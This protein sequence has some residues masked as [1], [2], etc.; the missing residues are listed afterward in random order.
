MAVEGSMGIPTALVGSPMGMG[1]YC[2][3]TLE[4]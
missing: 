1:M 3:F 4:C 2:T